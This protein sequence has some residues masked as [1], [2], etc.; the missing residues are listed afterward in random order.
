MKMKRKIKQALIFFPKSQ[1]LTFIE[2]GKAYGLAPISQEEYEE[3]KEFEHLVSQ[4]LFPY[5]S[6][7]MVITETEASK[8]YPELEGKREDD[9]EF[10]RTVEDI[11]IHERYIYNFY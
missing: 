7:E 11:Q 1:T 10:F 5:S 2:E 6:D 9:I 4:G 3:I 8:A